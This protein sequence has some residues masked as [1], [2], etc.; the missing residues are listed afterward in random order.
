MFFPQL[1]CRSICRQRGGPLVVELVAL[2]RVAPRGAAQQAHRR[3]SVRS[4][5]CGRAGR[6]TTSA[7][8]K[9]VSG[10]AAIFGKKSGLASA[11]GVVFS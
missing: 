11:A 6:G 1:G 8:G 9:R 2:R 3:M 5:R 10:V 4:A 7:T